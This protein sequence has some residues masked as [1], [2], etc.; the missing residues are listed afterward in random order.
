MP[1]PIFDNTSPLYQAASAILLRLRRSKVFCSGILSVHQTATCMVRAI[2]AGKPAK[3]TVKQ[4]IVPP[5]T[6]LFTINRQLNRKLNKK[7]YK[8]LNKKLK[9]KLNEKLDKKLKN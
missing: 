9:K 6:R 8:Q 4:N 5:I 3:A 1:E 7:L 2:S